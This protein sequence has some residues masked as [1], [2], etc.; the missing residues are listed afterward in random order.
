LAGFS[1]NW[2]RFSPWCGA[3]PTKHVTDTHQIKYTID[4]VHCFYSKGVWR[5]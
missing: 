3:Q 5:H 4:N 2:H 1:G